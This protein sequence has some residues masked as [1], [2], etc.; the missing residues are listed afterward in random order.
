MIKKYFWKHFPQFTYVYKKFLK[1]IL[2]S[3]YSFNPFNMWGLQSYFENYLTRAAPLLPFWKQFLNILKT[4]H[5]YNIDG[6]KE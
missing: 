6:L 5:M 3:W 4:M 1:N 2:P